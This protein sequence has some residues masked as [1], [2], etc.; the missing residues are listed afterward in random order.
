MIAIPCDHFW[1]GITG[2]TTGSLKR[3]ASF[4]HVAETEID[5]FQ[6]AVEVEQQIF[7]FQVPMANAKLVDVMYASQ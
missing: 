1:S 6:L 7:W 4:I 5:Y 2:A 3:L